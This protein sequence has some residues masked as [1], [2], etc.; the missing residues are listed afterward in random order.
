M[1]IK[2]LSILSGQELDFV[3]NTDIKIQNKTFKK[4]NSRKEEAQRFGRK[5]SA[6]RNIT[7]G[8]PPFGVSVLSFVPMTLYE[9]SQIK[10]FL[11]KKTLSGLPT[12]HLLI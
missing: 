3:S 7:V 12:P 10:R 4:I 6:F 9:A 1:L 2:N 8:K 5:F 11:K